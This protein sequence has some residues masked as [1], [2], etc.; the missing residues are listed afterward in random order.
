MERERGREE[1]EGSL[2]ASG[3]HCLPN[4]ETP[5]RTMFLS[6]LKTYMYNN[7]FNSIL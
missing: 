2:G 1:R 4:Y 3:T 5:H 6:H 7:H